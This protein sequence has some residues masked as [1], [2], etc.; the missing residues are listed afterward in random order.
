MKK[1]LPYLLILFAVT[2]Y[3]QNNS[4][5]KVAISANADSATVR[6]TVTA[7]QSY[8]GNIGALYYNRQSSKWRI[9]SDSTWS[10]LITTGGGGGGI[11]TVY[12]Y[13]GLT[14]VGNDSVRWGG[15]L[16]QNTSIVQA[17]FNTTF[18]GIGKVTFSPTK[19]VGSVAGLNIG[20]IAGNPTTVANGD[21]WYNSSTNTTNIYTSSSFGSLPY[22]TVGAGDLVASRVVYINN[23]F[24]RLT[25]NAG[26][27]ASS[28][29]VTVPRLVS[30]SSATL[31]AINVG[32]LAGDPS[33]PVNGDINY[34][35]STHAFRVRDNGAWET[36]S[37]LTNGAG[38][39]VFPL[40]N[41]TNLVGSS[42]STFGSTL[43]NVTMTGNN[44]TQT[45]NANFT[46]TITSAGSDTQILIDETQFSNNTA[47][48]IEFCIVGIK[49]DGSASFSA[50]RSAIVRQDNTGT[51]TVDVQGTV[52]IK[53]SVGGTVSSLNIV[54]NGSV[55]SA[56]LVMGG[57][58]GTY[59]IRGSSR[60]ISSSL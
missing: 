35:S 30:T 48:E 44:I 46:G 5:F 9:F 27:T 6:N 41:G 45:V 8:Y 34:N 12:A 58:S 31:S 52:E 51:W 53:E 56:T 33:S 40:S 2:G 57:A 50:K 47:L 13:N 59:T 14:R 22:F 28:T 39:N 42:L 17:G 15:T 23:S 21:F 55:P 16:T 32:S 20:S 38:S 4:V 1:I 11:D 60:V 18:S 19:G 7:S 29:V 26:F 43:T 24:G 49:S 3:A 10:D 25:S 37:Y 54:I 36:L